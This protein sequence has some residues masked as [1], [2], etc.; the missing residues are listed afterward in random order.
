MDTRSGW[1]LQG[2][3]WFYSSAFEVSSF[4]RPFLP[5]RLCLVTSLA[6]FL[7]MGSRGTNNSLQTAPVFLTASSGGEPLLH[8]VMPSTDS[9]GGNVLPS[10]SLHVSQA[11]VQPPRLA[12]PGISPELVAL[13]S[14]TVQAALAAEWA[15]SSAASTASSLSSSSA[16][17]QSSAT[18][19]CSGGLP[20]SSSFASSAASFLAA[21]TGL[22]VNAV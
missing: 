6:C 15:S 16:V 18:P 19:H 2:V 17:S 5:F 8:Q 21:G 12:T 13:I 4:S 1:G 20:E 9:T 22:G 11:G 3:A 10:N 14:Q 7:V